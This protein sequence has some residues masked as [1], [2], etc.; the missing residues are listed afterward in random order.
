MPQVPIKADTVSRNGASGVLPIVNGLKAKLVEIDAGIKEPRR[1]IVVLDDQT[2]AFEQFC[3]GL[4]PGR[5][6]R[7]SRL[8]VRLLH[9]Q[10]DDSWKSY[11]SIRRRVLCELRGQYDYDEIHS[12]LLERLAWM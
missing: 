10:D 2:A 8:K 4:W 11:H 7:C 5:R 9:V 6:K 12:Y 1:K 3:Q